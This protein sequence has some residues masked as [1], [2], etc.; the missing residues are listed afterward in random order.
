MVTSPSLVRSDFTL[1]QGPSAASARSSQATKPGAASATC[2]RTSTPSIV[3]A[4]VNVVS[5]E[6]TGASQPC[7]SAPMGPHPEGLRS[8][9]PALRCTSSCV[10]SQNSGS[11]VRSV[12]DGAMPEIGPDAFANQSLQLTSSSPDPD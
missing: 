5:R 9:E 8:A 6:T 4:T 3:A 7:P 11:S 10:T 1:A 2:Q 12:D